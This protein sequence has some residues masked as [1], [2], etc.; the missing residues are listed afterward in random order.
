M[1][2]LPFWNLLIL[3]KFYVLNFSHD[4]QNKS[5][6]QYEHFH[7][8]QSKKNSIGGDWNNVCIRQPTP[9]SDD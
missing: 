8:S 6:E 1:F 5:Y 3:G 7:N 9:R 4:F 2:F